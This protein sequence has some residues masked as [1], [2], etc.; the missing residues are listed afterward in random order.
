MRGRG[1]IAAAL[2]V[3]LAACAGP[4]RRGP[5][6]RTAAEADAL[7]VR[8]A[9]VNQDLTTFK[10]I[11]KAV[12]TTRGGTQTARVAWTGTIDRMIRI[13]VS[14]SGGPAAGRFCR[15]WPLGDHGVPRTAQISQDRLDGGQSEGPVGRP[16]VHRRHGFAD[17]RPCTD[18]RAPVG[19]A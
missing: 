12:V 2:L 14:E 18:S 19:P 9:A 16:G 7:L 5:E 1:L 10:G 4:W 17:H 8:L 3:T 15:R 13:E 11:G 6:D